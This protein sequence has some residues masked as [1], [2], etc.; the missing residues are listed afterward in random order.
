M[1]LKS[2]GQ[3]IPFTYYHFFS[4]DRFSVFQFVF[5]EE[6]DEPIILFLGETPALQYV[7]VCVCGGGGG[8]G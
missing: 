4:F 6:V 1:Q 3:L 2:F 7:S 5:D 8:G